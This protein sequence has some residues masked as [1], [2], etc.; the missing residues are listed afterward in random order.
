[1]RAIRKG[2]QKDTDESS[3][4]LEQ[5]DTELTKIEEE[6][7]RVAEE[8]K[9]ALVKFESVVVN[10]IAEEIKERYQEELNSLK[11]A[12]DKTCAEQKVTEEKVK[13]ITLMLSKQYETYLGK[14]ILTVA[15][16]DRLIEHIQSGEATTIKEALA[17][18]KNK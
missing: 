5:Y 11:V 12:Y 6:I 9:N 3:Y 7:A 1:M 17:L 13:E 8:E 18:E 15:M 10:Q 2:I 4:G 14:E 16:L